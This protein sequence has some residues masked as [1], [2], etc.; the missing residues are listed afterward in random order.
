MG[1]SLRFILPLFLALGLLTL[2]SMHLVDRQ[3]QQ[4]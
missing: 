4:W 2:G 3:V 1:L